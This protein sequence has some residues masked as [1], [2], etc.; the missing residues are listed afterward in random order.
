MAPLS[1]GLDTL[2]PN[3]PMHGGWGAMTCLRLNCALIALVVGLLVSCDKPYALPPVRDGDQVVFLGDSLTAYLPVTEITPGATNLGVP[4]WF[5]ADLN[6][7]VREKP[8]PK[9]RIYVLTIGT[10]DVNRNRGSL[11]HARLRMLSSRMPG[12]I[13]WNAIP[14]NANR[15]VGP[16]NKAIAQVCAERPDCV[17]LQTPFVPATDLL[18]DGVH[19]SGRGYDRWVAA[20]RV[21]LGTNR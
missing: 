8:L 13:L 19:L 3:K 10:N 2:R 11:I 15:D 6:R 5:I 18:E 9:A 4:G 16:A 21:A 17:F 12:P 20:L 7:F 1:H 14:P